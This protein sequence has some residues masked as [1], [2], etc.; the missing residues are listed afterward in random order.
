MLN[1]LR[2][3]KGLYTKDFKFMLN[4]NLELQESTKISEISKHIVKYGFESEKI[5]M[6]SLKSLS[7]EGKKWLSP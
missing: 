5:K 3:Q 7:V 1:K 4:Q 2:D 6:L